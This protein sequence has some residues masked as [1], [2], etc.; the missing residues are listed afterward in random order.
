M[1][2][3]H[4]C[5]IGT[6]GLSILSITPLTLILAFLATYDKEKKPS[7]SLFYLFALGYN[8]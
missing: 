3:A 6:L 5:V 1:T 8:V 7:S 4:G 2:D